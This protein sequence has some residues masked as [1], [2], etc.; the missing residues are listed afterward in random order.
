MCACQ[1]IDHQYRNRPGNH[2]GLR[3]LI[4]PQAIESMHFG[5]RPDLINETGAQTWDFSADPLE[6]SLC[7]P[8]I[9]TEAEIYLMLG[10]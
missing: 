7:V 3:T 2:R 6:H 10:L 1:V 9:I 5:R 8:L 4:H